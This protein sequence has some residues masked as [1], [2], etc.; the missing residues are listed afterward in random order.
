M[1]GALAIAVPL[2]LRG[3]QLLHSRHGSLPWAELVEQVRADGRLLSMPLS[4]TRANLTALQC[5][6]R[7]SCNTAAE[8]FPPHLQVIPCAEHGFP[9]HPYI[10]AGLSANVT[11]QVAWV[12]ALC[13]LLPALL[14]LF[15]PLS[16]RRGHTTHAGDA[17]GPA[18]ARGLLDTGPRRLAAAAREGNL[19]PPP[20]A[21][22]AP[23]GRCARGCLAVVDGRTSETQLD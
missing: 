4:G 18:A 10:I 13:R 17:R 7:S 5:F 8:S 15:H 20:P 16:Y 12:S 21:G 19:L 9:A 3:L 2:E 11:L 23:P 6:T 22:R 1:K 14:L